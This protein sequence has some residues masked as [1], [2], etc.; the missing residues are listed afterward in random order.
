MS[1][2][3]RDTQASIRWKARPTGKYPQQGESMQHIFREIWETN[4]WGSHES[5]SGPGSN[6]SETLGIGQQLLAW[7]KSYNCHSLFDAPCGD[8][9][10][11]QHIDFAAER[12]Q[13]GGMDILPE[14]VKTARA[15]AHPS[16]T[17]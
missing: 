16:F 9:N 5:R 3:W 13:V 1:N 15:R 2:A 12:I 10:W 4:A 8:W 7:M 6:L 17:F 14:A 11:M